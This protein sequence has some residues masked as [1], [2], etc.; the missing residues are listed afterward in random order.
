MRK[1]KNKIFL[2]IIQNSF[3]NKNC[4]KTKTKKYSFVLAD[5]MYGMSLLIIA[6]GLGIFIGKI[7]TNLK[8]SNEKLATL[9]KL[10]EFGTIQ[11]IYPPTGITINK[12]ILDFK[13]VSLKDITLVYKIF[14][15]DLKTNTI[16][17]CFSDVIKIKKGENIIPL[18]LT[19]CI[20]SS[21]GIIQIYFLYEG[22]LA[23]SYFIKYSNKTA[24]IIFKNLPLRNYVRIGEKIFEGLPEITYNVPAEKNI[25]YEMV[26]PYY[27]VEGT[28]FLSPGEEKVINPGTFHYKNITFTVNSY[29]TDIYT[30]YL[31]GYILGSISPG[32]HI[33]IPYKEDYKVKSFSIYEN[34]KIL[35]N[36]FRIRLTV[37]NGL[38]PINIKEFEICLTN[39]SRGIP[40]YVFIQNTKE[41]KY[42]DH[43]CS[44][45]SVNNGAFILLPFTND[46]KSNSI[47]AYDLKFEKEKQYL[48]GEGETSPIEIVL[49]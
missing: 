34:D 37:V 19:K 39:G 3:K 30:L 14:F 18:D 16:S 24:L 8:E 26:S 13:F 6:I 21:D 38:Y 5:F 15:K 2:Y 32:D 33:T 31:N 29:T 27:Y 22:N 49:S 10:R 7:V 28:L 44:G 17:Y 9:K 4:P 45:S 36:L 1:R 41:L 48:V 20:N 23:F 47:I 12:K 25:Y 43:K 46:L 35:L 40:G 11:V 42:T